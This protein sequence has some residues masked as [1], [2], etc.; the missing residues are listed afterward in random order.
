MD[1]KDLGEDYGLLTI[2]VVHPPK[3]STERRLARNGILTLN[4]GA[5]TG[6]WG[7]KSDWLV[8]LARHGRAHHPQRRQAQGPRDHGPTTIAELELDKALSRFC[9]RR[10]GPGVLRKE[11]AG[12][13]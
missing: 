5:D 9:V 6:H 10:L 2:V 12:D 3:D 1:L 13:E 11:R 4:D 8:H 7:N